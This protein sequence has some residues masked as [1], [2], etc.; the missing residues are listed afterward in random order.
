MRSRKAEKL[1][2][3]TFIL[4]K[5]LFLKFGCKRVAA[6]CLKRMLLCDHFHWTRHPFQE[7]F[8]NSRRTSFIL[9]RNAPIELSPYLSGSIL[10]EE[11]FMKLTLKL[12]CGCYPLYFSFLE[13]NIPHFL[14]NV[15]SFFQKYFIVFVQ[16]ICL[17]FILTQLRKRCIIK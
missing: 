12:P 2:T 5:K 6:D 17:N 4:P 3:L 15:N 7:K 16:Y 14:C 10:S 1:R 11:N 8:P 9:K 13:Y